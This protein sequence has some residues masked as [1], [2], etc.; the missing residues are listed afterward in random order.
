MCGIFYSTIQPKVFDTTELEKRGPDYK[1]NCSNE[2]GFFYHSNLNTIPN[3][4]SQPI[5]NA[6]GTLLYNGT[7]FDLQN[8]DTDF[9][10]QILD[11]NTDHNK[12]AISSLNG[13]YSIIWVTNSMIMLARDFGGNKPLWYGF[14]QDVFCASNNQLAILQ[15]NLQPIMV[16]SNTVLVFDRKDTT[17]KLRDVS[18]IKTFDLSQTVTTLDHVIDAFETAVLARYKPGTV[19]PMSSGMDSGCIAACLQKYN[20]TFLIATRVGHEDHKILNQRLE[21]CQQHQYVFNDVD[22]DTIKTVNRLSFSVMPPNCQ[23]AQV[24]YQIASYASSQG[25]RYCLSGTGADEVYSD[26]GWNGHKHNFHSQFGGIFPSNLS[27]IWPWMHNK[28]LPLYYCILIEDYVYGLNGMDTRNPFLD[29]DLI[30]SWLNTVL[31]LKNK[32]YKCWQQYYM[33]KLNFP[34]NTDKK[35]LPI[36][37]HIRTAVYQQNKLLYK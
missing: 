36:P 12:Q 37:R 28:T 25:Y 22:I 23:T 33:T 30:Q 18:S 24:G 29:V 26:Y 34:Y 7:Q 20:K 27:T 32:K 17:A 5:S 11:N 35:T 16:E 8:N 1:V 13:D 19:L 4:V 3:N 9:I 31:E 15:Q 14:D 2:L 6:Y 10:C 21:L